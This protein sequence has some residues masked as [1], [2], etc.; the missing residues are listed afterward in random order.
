M[1]IQS[2]PH[3]TT[4][5]GS[6]LAHAPHLHHLTV[7]CAA[8]TACIQLARSRWPLWP[9]SDAQGCHLLRISEQHSG[10]LASM[11]QGI[12]EIR[13]GTETSSR[14]SPACTGAPAAISLSANK[15]TPPTASTSTARKSRSHFSPAICRREQLHCEI[16]SESL[17]ISAKLDQTPSPI[18]V[19]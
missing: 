3:A 9:H 1:E 15:S 7:S 10:R 8:P 19:S 14:F 17:G 13:T 5:P 6:P 11:I 4:I 16:L 12:G 2:N 18:S